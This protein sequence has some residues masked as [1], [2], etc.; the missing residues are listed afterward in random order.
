MGD[1]KLVQDW[2]KGITDNWELYNLSK[3]RTEIKNIISELPDKADQM[4]NMY[5]NRAKNIG[6]IAWEGLEKI[7]NKKD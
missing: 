5:N 6:V 1:Y 7:R 4:V 2:E 3:D